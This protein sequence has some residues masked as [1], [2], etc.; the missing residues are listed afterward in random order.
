MSKNSLLSGQRGA[1]WKSDG[2]NVKQEA[3][4]GVSQAR[5]QSAVPYIICFPN[6][7][8]RLGAERGPGGVISA[9]Y[10][11]PCPAATAGPRQPPEILPIILP[12]VLSLLV[13]EMRKGSGS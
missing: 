1:L 11:Q 8:G 6:E 2:R 12:H 13:M 3:K 10:E 5:L 4:R 7:P 9:A